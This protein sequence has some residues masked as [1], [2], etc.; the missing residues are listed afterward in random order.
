[1]KTVYET[2]KES[3]KR[4]GELGSGTCGVVYKARFEQTGT[5]MAVKVAL[6]LLLVFEN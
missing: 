3:L 1:M 5:I 4:I 2:K 6:L